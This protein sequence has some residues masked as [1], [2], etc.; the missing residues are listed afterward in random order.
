MNWDYS[1]LKLSS[2]QQFDLPGTFQDKLIL[3]T[4]SYGVKELLDKGERE[5]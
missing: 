1:F 5:K 4:T 2:E 3:L